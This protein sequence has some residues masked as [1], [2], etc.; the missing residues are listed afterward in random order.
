M[1]SF[2]S[3]SYLFYP[4]ASLIFSCF[5]SLLYNFLELRFF[6]LFH[7]PILKSTRFLNL[8]TYLNIVSYPILWSPSSHNIGSTPCSDYYYSLHLVFVCFHVVPLV[9]VFHLPIC[10]PVLLFIP[11]WLCLLVALHTFLAFILFSSFEYLYFFVFNCYIIL[12]LS[13][14]NCF[15]LNQLFHFSFLF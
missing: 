1:L 11:F 5:I 2:I 15:S 10:C 7:N 8:N 9:Y 12:N 14:Q 4:H 13:T 3:H 6:L